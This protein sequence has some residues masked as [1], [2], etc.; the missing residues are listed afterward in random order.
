MHALQNMRVALT[1]FGCNVHGITPYLKHIK[2][3]RRYENSILGQLNILLASYCR[4]LKASQLLSLG[5]KL[6]RHSSYVIER[7]LRDTCPPEL[8]N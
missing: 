3:F 6:R 4:Y 8:L 7:L 1:S 2:A 5:S